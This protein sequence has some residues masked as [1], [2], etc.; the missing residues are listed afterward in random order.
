M[1]KILFILC[2]S[3]SMMT[4]VCFANEKPAPELGSV[5]GI[6]DVDITGAPTIESG[7]IIGIKGDG[8]EYTRG[9]CSHHRGVDYC[10][11]SVGRLVCNDGTYSPSCR[12]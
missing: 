11:S 9:C 1:K 8:N 7:S 2:I 4:A 6:T 12:C 10:D 3:F 5:M